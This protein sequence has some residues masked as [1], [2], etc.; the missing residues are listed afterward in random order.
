MNEMFEEYADRIFFDNTLYA[1]FWCVVILAFGIIFK[2]IISKVISWMIYFSFRKYSK[3]VGISKFHFL[4][5]RPFAIFILL[6]TLYAAFDKL[7]F[8]SEWNM[9][10]IEHIGLRL[11]IY[12]TFQV[13]MTLSI[14]W[15]ILRFIDFIGDIYNYRAILND[16]NSKDQLIT[17]VR[18]GFKILVGIICLMIILGAIFKIN[19]TSLIAGLGIGGLAIALAAKETIENLLG[20]FTIFLDKPFK[21]GDLVKV[22]DVTGNIEKIGFRSTRIRTLEK[23]FVTIPN[24]KM[25]D[26]SLDN[27]SLRSTRRA[28]FNVS[29]TYDTSSDQLK[30]IVNDLQTYLDSNSKT[31]NGEAIIRL[32]E[33][34][35]TSL[36]IMV[37][38]F[39]NTMEYEE[40]LKVREEVN[41][42]IMEIVEKYGAE[43]AYP[44]H[45]S[46]HT[47]LEEIIPN[48]T[49]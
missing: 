13:I 32:F 4:L 15:I 18:D 12:R 28:A 23:S 31:K 24:K 41:Y 21:Q 46:V 25:V 39:V 42:K 5:D 19:L 20:S 2:K 27:L 44:D 47:K 9:V 1:W 43:F 48:K 16:T 14:T 29:L 38:Y 6:L 37:L 33:F 11:I 35:P 34:S 45:Y 36:N 17:F 8:P 7:H 10:S 22:G 40:Y 3:G 26:T 30:G 49:S